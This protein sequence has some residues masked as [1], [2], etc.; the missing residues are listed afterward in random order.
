MRRLLW[1]LPGVEGEEFVVV[2]TW[3]RGEAFVVVFTWSRG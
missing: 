2:F 1:C 3:S